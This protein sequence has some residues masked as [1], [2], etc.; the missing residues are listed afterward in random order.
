VLSIPK[1]SVLGVLG[2]MADCQ[3][4]SIG[5]K[6]EL[7][8]LIVSSATN[9]VLLLAHRF[10]SRTRETTPSLQTKKE[11][12]TS[13]LIGEQLCSA[14]CYLHA[15]ASVGTREILSCVDVT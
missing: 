10:N 4:S 14:A 13:A 11:L 7:D 9:G 3:E 15:V 2:S 1:K 12:S 6:E 5:E 8:C